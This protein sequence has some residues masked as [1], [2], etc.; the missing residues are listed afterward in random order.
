[1][2]SKNWTNLLEILH[3]FG[4]A[5]FHLADPSLECVVDGVGLFAHVPGRVVQDVV[6]QRAHLYRRHPLVLGA[7][8]VVVVELRPRLGRR[9][10]ATEELV[11]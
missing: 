6:A 10:S 1:M 8:H 3:E 2:T 7:R 5:V 9:L 11:S 4:L